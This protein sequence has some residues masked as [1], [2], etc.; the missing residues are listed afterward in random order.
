VISI[1]ENEQNAIERE[2]MEKKTADNKA[3]AKSGGKK[4]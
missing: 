1:I 4:K 3:K 2:E